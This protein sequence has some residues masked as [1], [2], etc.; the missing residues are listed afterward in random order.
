MTSGRRR[1]RRVLGSLLLTGLLTLTSA[2]GDS[3]ADS[4]GKT[5]LTWWDYFGYSPSADNAVKNLIARYE[6]SHPNVT[7]S[8]TV[9][10]F[11]DFRAKLQEAAKNG[12]FPDLAAIDNAD[13]PVFAKQGVLTDLT[14]RVQ[15]WDALK[16]YLDPVVQS[17]QVNKQFYGVPFRSNTTALWYNKD[18]FAAAG[19]TEPP[20]TWDELVASARKLT[21]GDHAGLCF[22][23]AANEEGTFT[24]LP[25]LWQAGGD[26][27]GLGDK[28]SVTALNLV[29]KLINQDK[30]VPK[31]MLH[32]GQSDIGREF[33]AGRC[34]MMINGPWVLSSV[35]Q[36]KFGWDVA[37]WP[38]G[39]GGNSASPL[40]G[41]V[42]AVGKGSAH[43]EE[44]WDVARWIADPR[45]SW[46][47]LGKGLSGIPNRKDTVT[48]QA[49]AWSP[50]IPVFAHQMLS[51]RAR[52]SYGDKY[53]QVSQVVWLMEQEVLAHARPPREAAAAAG[54][55]VKPLLG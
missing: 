47:E 44:A 51:A 32:S 27:R 39:S 20:K 45:N 34:S 30:S 53:A 23:A 49:W 29:D 55:Q 54:A 46:A 50:I 31:S 4:A 42:L 10:R 3:E 6:K 48:D 40:G 17:V 18:H 7:V 15:M 37:L 22:S 25:L 38:T 43:V 24:F 16:E 36:A 8:R 52:G 41:E 19:V 21:N 14:S 12:T 28:A 1:A 26:L 33:G 35:E 11:G 9:V 5:V 13:V 2:C